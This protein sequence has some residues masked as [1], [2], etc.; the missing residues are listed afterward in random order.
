LTEKSKQFKLPELSYGM[1]EQEKAVE[2]EVTDEMLQAAGRAMVE[3]AKQ[4][5]EAGNEEKAE[6]VRMVGRGFVLQYREQNENESLDKQEE[7]SQD[8]K[9]MNDSL[10]YVK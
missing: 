9:E 7:E 3:R 5:R 4:M 1:V 10:H 2:I 8:R 6:E